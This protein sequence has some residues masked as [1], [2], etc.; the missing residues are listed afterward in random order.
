MQKTTTKNS[1]VEAAAAIRRVLSMTY[2][3]TKFRVTSRSFAGG[4]DVRVSWT[5]GPTDAAV[6]SLVRMYE[7]GT[8]DGMTD[9]YQYDN[10][11]RDLPQAKYV[12]VSRH[13]SDATCARLM[14]YLGITD[15]EGWNDKHNAWNSM[16]VNRAFRDLNLTA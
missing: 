16:L 14:A 7:M 9:S 8:F 10:V 5:D 15:Y 13:L 1:H 11:Q 4:N 3:T 2:P 12:T 6:Q